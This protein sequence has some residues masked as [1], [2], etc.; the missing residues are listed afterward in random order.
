M[1]LYRHSRKQDDKGYK[2]KERKEMEIKVS[3][4]D[5]ISA[6]FRID[7]FY[8]RLEANTELKYV[9][10][11]AE[12]LIR[13]KSAGVND[14]AVLIIPGEIYSKG[15]VAV[16]YM[17]LKKIVT[18]IKRDKLISIHA[19]NAKV[20]LW[21]EGEI[22][23]YFLAF[24]NAD[25]IPTME[26]RAF[27]AQYVCIKFKP[28]PFLLHIKK[29]SLFMCKEY[30]KESNIPSVVYIQGGKNYMHML[31][32]DYGWCVHSKIKKEEIIAEDKHN[33]AEKLDI[34]IP[35]NIVQVLQ[36]IPSTAISTL[37][38]IN[39][40]IAKEIS[41]IHLGF[42]LLWVRLR[43]EDKFP[44]ASELLLTKN[45]NI[46]RINRKKFNKVLKPFKS[47][48]CDDGTPYVEMTFFENKLKIVSEPEKTEITSNCGTLSV[49]GIEIDIVY[50]GESIRVGMN[51]V[52]LAN[53]LSCIDTD[54][55]IIELRDDESL[56]KIHN[57][58]NF[59]LFCMP[60]KT[61]VD[62]DNISYD[63]STH[64]DSNKTHIG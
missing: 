50:T 29:A 11:E 19:T 15:T 27:D 2:N 12:E 32:S 22:T 34:N 55:F 6:L 24:V 40:Y 63:V 48:T 18:A 61:V 37:T 3:N 60:C 5:L 30:V 59:E 20:G 57:N 10:I 7:K 58:T 41:A 25:L 54:E 23:E 35:Y 42:T 21:V 13:I 14:G 52:T 8:N 1:I 9:R 56:M 44:D 46:A 43:K 64:S 38:T 33:N 36:L 26:K 31:A 4:S 47:C 51:P 17:Q 45:D 28:A 39:L 62:T 49:R 16:E 53:Y